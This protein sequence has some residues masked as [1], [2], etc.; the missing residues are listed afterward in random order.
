MITGIAAA[1]ARRPNRKET[2]GGIRLIGEL[3]S[4]QFGLR[5][6]A[7]AGWI[8][9]TDDEGNNTENGRW[10]KRELRHAPTRPTCCHSGSKP[11]PSHLIL[12]TSAQWAAF[13]DI[14]ILKLVVR[15]P[16]NIAGEQETILFHEILNIR[17][18]EISEKCSELL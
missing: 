1:T 9:V 3:R 6:T 12:P 5:G 15:Q 2:S 8:W 10:C 13:V 11:L 7:S 17:V 18:V 14:K 16:K 4:P